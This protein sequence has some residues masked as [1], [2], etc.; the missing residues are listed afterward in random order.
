[1]HESILNAKGAVM[2]KF[3][4]IVSL[5]SCTIVYS[6]NAAAETRA[7]PISPSSVRSIVPTKQS[8]ISVS[9]AVAVAELIDKI[10]I[11]EIKLERITDPAKLKNIRAEYAVLQA[12]YQAH[13]PQ[14]TELEQLKKEL[15]EKNKRLWDLE[16]AIRAK[17]NSKTFDAEFIQLARE[18]YLNNDARG[19]IK[20]DINALVGSHIIEEKSYGEYRTDAAAQKRSW[21]TAST[22]AGSSATITVTV[23]M[24]IGE[25]VDKITILEIKQQNI[26]NPEKLK[27]ITTEL[28]ILYT[29]L[30]EH[31]SLSPELA[32]LIDKLREQNKKMW[33]IEDRIREKEKMHQFDAKFIQLARD[34]YYTND[35]RCAVK[36][37]INVL[38][39]S[40]LMEEKK[41]TEYG[42]P[43][44]VTA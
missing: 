5:V 23:E 43:Q 22:K 11:L 8:D 1:M 6:L 26:S 42:Q 34:V 21:N 20:R 15:I 4:S 33:D 13:V 37:E 24:P 38:L 40:R 27:N 29:T 10:T 17:E 16:D 19:L 28:A 18:I 39:E 44:P 35:K 32:A 2:R 7:C 25:L 14:S 3:F 31:V 30:K 9:A 36:R 41:Y 12:M